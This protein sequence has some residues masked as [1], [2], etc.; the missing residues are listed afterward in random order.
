MK[1]VIRSAA[2]FYVIGNRV[3]IEG[4]NRGQ[5]G[6]L[7]TDA[8]LMIP[9]RT[10]HGWVSWSMYQQAKEI[11]CKVG[12]SLMKMPKVKLTGH[13]LGGSVAILLAHIMLEAGYT[14]IIYVYAAG[15]PKVLSQEAAEFLGDK[16]PMVSWRVNQRDIVPYLGWWREP[17]HV[18]PR[19]GRERKHILDWTVMAHS[20]Y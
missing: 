6:D 14:G 12:W 1:R 3:V 5:I 8:L 11:F 15:S 17:I 16:L 7:L 10:K 19:E 4:T 20:E 9:K 18:T 2:G 13:S